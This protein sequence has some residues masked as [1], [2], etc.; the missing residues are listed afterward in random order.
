MN[1]ITN[2]EL[3]QYFKQI[4]LLLPIFGKEEKKFLRDFQIAVKEYAENQ[5]NSCTLNDVKERFGAPDDIVHEYIS[6]LDQFRLCN[7]IHL[8]T[9]LKK[10]FVIIVILILIA[11][12]FTMVT[13]YSAYKEAQEKMASYAVTV[14]D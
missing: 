7:R 9:I 13:T 14:I 12:S 1:P 6:S 8:R 4:K 5:S 2:D 3:Q 11:F 10:I